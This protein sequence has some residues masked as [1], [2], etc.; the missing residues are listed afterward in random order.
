MNIALSSVAVIQKIL[1]PLLCSSENYMNRPE[2]IINHKQ[3]F[4]FFAIQNSAD[5]LCPLPH[6]KATK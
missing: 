5:R 2:K 6:K 4:F 1:F 3:F